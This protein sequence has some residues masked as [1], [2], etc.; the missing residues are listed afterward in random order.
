MAIQQLTEVQKKMLNSMCISA[1][2]VNMGT[3]LSNIITSV[4]EGGTGF[5]PVATVEVAGKV[6]ASSEVVVNADGVMGIGEIERGKIIGL[7]EELNT[8]NQDIK[9]IMETGVT[10]TVVEKIDTVQNS[11]ATVEKDV[12][13]VE[14]KV[15]TV[16]QKMTTVETK[17][18]NIE[19]DVSWG[20]F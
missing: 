7:E 11:V 3:L 16:E 6:K 15:D 14:V 4:N 12:E 2:E 13:V 19:E 9:S 17:L 1:Q 18:A 5:V 20:N 8:L 10:V